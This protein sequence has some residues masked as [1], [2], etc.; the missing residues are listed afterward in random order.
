MGAAG[1]MASGSCPQPY[2][3]FQASYAVQKGPHGLFA[4]RGVLTYS[5]HIKIIPMAL[6]YLKMS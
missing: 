1:E 5:N 6:A 4:E 2:T 3:S